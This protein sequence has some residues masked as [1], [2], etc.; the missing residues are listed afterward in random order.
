MNSNKSYFISFVKS[1]ESWAKW[2]LKI[3]E[4]EGHKVTLSDNAGKLPQPNETLIALLSKA[5]ID[6][7]AGKDEWITAYTG[8]R[9]GSERAI[10]PVRVE[11]N[12]FP[13]GLL[14]HRVFIDIFGNISDEER[15]R[16][17]LSALSDEKRELQESEYQNIAEREIK[18]AHNL[19]PAQD[20]PADALRELEE[21][22]LHDPH[23]VA[24][25]AGASARNAALSFAWKHIRKYHTVWLVNAADEAGLDLAYK[26]IAGAKKLPAHSGA[27]EIRD[28]VREWLENDSG[29]LLVF[30]DAQD[31]N[32]LETYL[33]QE[34]R[35]GIIITV[36]N[37]GDA[38]ILMLENVIINCA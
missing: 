6:S 15:A 5:Y 2:L 30:D 13:T 19:P 9:K 27:D 3:L 26:Q 38:S 20:A 31:L 36:Q 18:T 33:P 14:S 29:G 16:R 8:D 4:A 37:A 7:E 1:D 28:A 25:L 34:A 23:P 24:V 12:V 35:G 17:L 21:T 10:I 22:L 32:L 11:N